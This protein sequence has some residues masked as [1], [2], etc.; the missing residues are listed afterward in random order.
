MKKVVKA[1]R[2]IN[3]D[4]EM[5]RGYIVIEN[6]KI[7]DVTSDYQI[8]GDEQVIDASTYDVYPGAIDPHTH[9]NDP[10]ETYSEDF[11]SGTASAAAGGITTVLDMPVT[12]PLVDNKEALLQ[13]IQIAEEKAVVDVGLW[14]AATPDNMDSFEELAEMGAIGFKAY[15]S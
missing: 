12:I 8:T 10:G 3:S 9:L 4:M 5:E 14:C 13:K 11:Y 2:I 7:V 15:L 1:G 6:D